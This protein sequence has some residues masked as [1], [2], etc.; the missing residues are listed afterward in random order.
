MHQ[1]TKDWPIKTQNSSIIF[2]PNLYFYTAHN[3]MKTRFFSALIFAATVVAVAVPGQANSAGATQEVTVGP[4]IDQFLAMLDGT[5]AKAQAAIDK[6]GSPEVIANKMIPFGKNPKIIK[7]EG[8]C[9]RVS[10]QHDGETN[11][12]T[13][14]E[15]NGKISS[16]DWYFDEEE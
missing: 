16:F 3:F 5:E 7:T 8:N 15:A 1:P 6:F 9:V 10:L 4:I 11:V 13:L 12:Y 14:C 2:A